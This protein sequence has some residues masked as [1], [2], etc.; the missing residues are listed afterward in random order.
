MSVRLFST[1]ANDPASLRGS[2]W[3]I[4]QRRAIVTE[5]SRLGEDFSCVGRPRERSMC[6]LWCG[7][8]PQPSPAPF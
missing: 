2:Q 1:A 7:R 8:R 5:R 6:R 4:D 3:T